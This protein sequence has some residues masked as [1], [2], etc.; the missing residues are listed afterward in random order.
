MYCK[1]HDHQ[2]EVVLGRPLIG[3]LKQHG[4]HLQGQVVQSEPAASTAV[5]GGM[6][7]ADPQTLSQLQALV[8]QQQAVQGW[9][10][11]SNLLQALHMQQQLQQSAGSSMGAHRSCVALMRHITLFNIVARWIWTLPNLPQHCR[12]L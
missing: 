9:H 2:S 12:T 8:Q 10:N 4:W 1:V 5:S 6:L 3:F 11:A 7:I